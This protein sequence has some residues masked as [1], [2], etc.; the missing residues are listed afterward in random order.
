MAIKDLKP[1]RTVELISPLPPLPEKYRRIGDSSGTHWRLVAE[2]PDEKKALGT[3]LSVTIELFAG[4]MPREQRKAFEVASKMLRGGIKA[5]AARPV[6]DREVQDL[7][8][9]AFK[10]AGVPNQNQTQAAIIR[11]VMEVLTRNGKQVSRSVVQKYYRQYLDQQAIRKKK[12]L[13][14]KDDR[15]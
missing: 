6:L 13:L 1:K 14:A 4:V 10:T 15:R 9:C 7:L 11:A 2:F 12:Y 5:K 3:A 8:R